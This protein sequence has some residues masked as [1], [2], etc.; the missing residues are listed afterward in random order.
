[1]QEYAVGRVEQLQAMLAADPGDAFLRYGLALE[2]MKLGR[3]DEALAGFEALLRDEPTYVP[4]HFMH[5]RA[6]EQ[7]DDLDR[8]RAAYRAGID[9]AR[10]TGDT[11]AAA[12]MTAALEALGE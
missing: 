7:T 5:A 10:R 1:M 11:H 12:E 2:Y 8:A 6:L 4:A 9:V 3:L